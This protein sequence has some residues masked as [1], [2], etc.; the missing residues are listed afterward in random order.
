MAYVNVNRSNMDQFYRYK[1]PSLMAKVEGKGNGIKTVIVNMVEVAKALNRPASYTCKYF[2]CELGAQTQ[3][4]IKNARYIVNGAHE[5]GKL[6]DM[7]DGF[8]RRF[9]LCP[10]CENPETELHVQSAKGRIGQ[11]CKAC[12]YHGMV[13]MRHKLTTFILKNPPT[14]GEEA[15][16][17]KKDKKSRRLEKQRG[18]GKTNGKDSAVPTSPTNPPP[19]DDDFLETPPPPT[20]GTVHGDE[21]WSVDTSETAVKDRMKKLTD[22]ASALTITSDLE[23]TSA[24]RVDL[25][26]KFVEDIKTQGGASAVAG[27]LRKIKA[28]AE[29]LEVMD[30]AAGILA[31]LL[32]TE[33]LLS[34]IKEYRPIMLLFVVDNRKA[35]KY[36]LSAF[37][38]L[39]GKVHPVLLP[40]VPHILKAFYDNDL[41]D[42]EAILEWAD[43]V[44]KKHVKKEV[45]KQIHEKAAPFVSWL[46]T[47]EEESSEE[48]EE[49][50]GVEFSSKQTGTT[51]AVQPEKD[52]EGEVDDIDIDDI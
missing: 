34:E 20:N 32:Y 47:A 30:K 51:L 16:S 17:G 35:Q 44:H 8:I 14:S 21:D 10:E 29:K 12:G 7:L 52:E 49:E 23:K 42:E 40:K 15:S 13:D 2:G 38:I 4:D 5:S 43:K 22:Q 36:L 50:V 41:L 31:E 18:K 9:V 6:Q 48:E 1:M 39:V 28:E 46:R 27:S 37:E 33:K 26:Y 24:E 25:F 11:S 45:A 3:M 19:A